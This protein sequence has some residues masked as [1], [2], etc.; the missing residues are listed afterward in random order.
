MGFNVSG[1]STLNF[2]D[3]YMVGLAY[4]VKGVILGGSTT[5][6]VARV[7]LQGTVTN[8]FRNHH[9]VMYSSTNC[10]FSSRKD[11]GGAC[12]PYNVQVSLPRYS[13][14]CIATRPFCPK[15]SSSSCPPADTKYS[16]FQWRHDP[17]A[18]QIIPPPGWIPQNCDDDNFVL[19]NTTFRGIS[20]IVLDKVLPED[21]EFST[22]VYPVI[23]LRPSLLNDGITRVRSTPPNALGVQIAD[24]TTLV[25]FHHD[26]NGRRPDRVGIIVEVPARELGRVAVTWGFYI[27]Q[28]LPGFSNLAELGYGSNSGMIFAHLSS[29]A[30]VTLTAQNGGSSL[31]VSGNAFVATESSDRVAIRG[32]VLGQSTTPAYLKE[33]FIEGSVKG[34]LS[35]QREGRIISSTGC[36]NI[37]LSNKAGFSSCHRRDY[38]S[39]TL[40]QNVCTATQY[41]DLLCHSGGC[42]SNQICVGTL[43][44][45]F[46]AVPQWHYDAESATCLALNQTT[47]PCSLPSA[48][49]SSVLQN[50]TDFTVAPARSPTVESLAPSGGT[51]AE[52]TPPSSVLQNKPDSTIAPARSPSVESL[53]S[54]S[55]TIA[56]KTHRF[57]LGGVSL[58]VVSLLLLRAI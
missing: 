52:K 36:S 5:M 45:G 47:R 3:Q 44:F 26:L 24:N 22:A 16:G 46:A 25:L 27:L 55:G 38:L 21:T 6:D 11:L 13:K 8:K 42:Q 48:P 43:G 32:D 19:Y 41:C 1:S 7:Y 40:P 51:E 56:E 53:A 37:T 4:A 29:N 9:G 15:G 20:S 35:I 54:S 33:M 57:F 2:F 17:V 30:P 31:I 18:Q 14:E 39:V 49:P 28:I 58:W 12:F 50:K 23:T 34:N 10:T